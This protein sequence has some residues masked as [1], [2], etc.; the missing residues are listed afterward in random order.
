M[1]I[2]LND[3][4]VFCMDLAFCLAIPV[5]QKRRKENLTQMLRIDK[6]ATSF[7]CSLSAALPKMEL[8]ADRTVCLQQQNNL[9]QC[10]LLKYKCAMKKF[11]SVNLLN[12]VKHT[13]LYM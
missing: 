9:V 1:I 11:S 13:K 3:T 2:S 12:I 10:T 6:V 5:Y 8:G 7:G 4:N